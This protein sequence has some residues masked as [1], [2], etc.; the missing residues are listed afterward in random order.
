VLDPKTLTVLPFDEELAYSEERAHLLIA[1][2]DSLNVPAELDPPKA[3]L[4]EMK[5]FGGLT[6]EESAEVVAM[7]ATAVR[8]ELRDRTGVAAARDGAAPRV[9]RNSPKNGCGLKEEVNITR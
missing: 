2:D 8:K 6:A 5:Y 1:V 7:P 9:I 3:R 4:V